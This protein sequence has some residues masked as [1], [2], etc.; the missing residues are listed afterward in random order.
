MRF[1]PVVGDKMIHF[2]P[3]TAFTNW[4]MDVVEDSAPWDSVG[5]NA[6]VFFGWALLLWILGIVAVERRDA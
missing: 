3:F 6:V 4:T 1:L 5:M 2:M